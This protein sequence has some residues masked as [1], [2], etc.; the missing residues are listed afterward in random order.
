MNTTGFGDAPCYLSFMH[1]CC[2]K[3]SCPGCVQY[4][5]QSAIYGSIILYVVAEKR[6]SLKI[7]K[8]WDRK[9]KKIVV[10]FQDMQLPYRFLKQ[11]KAPKLFT[12]KWHLRD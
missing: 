2:F 11:K 3:C 12:P 4:G 6:S 9:N 10:I 1:L 7:A 5:M 8:K